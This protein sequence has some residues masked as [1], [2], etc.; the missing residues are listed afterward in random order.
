[1]PQATQFDYSLLRGRIREFFGSEKN[2]A[3]EL[4]NSKINMSTG[5]F[6]NKINNKSYFS[7][8]EI[9]GMCSLL[10]IPVVEIPVYFFKEKY[11]LNS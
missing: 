1:M 7:Q 8:L 4:R 9:N 3:E 10:N 5:A 11:E 6:N 2:F